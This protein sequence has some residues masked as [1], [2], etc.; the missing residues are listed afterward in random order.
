M[1]ISQYRKVAG[2]ATRNNE[3]FDQQQL[4]QKDIPIK[5]T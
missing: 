5:N 3:F 1:L 2:Q 4:G